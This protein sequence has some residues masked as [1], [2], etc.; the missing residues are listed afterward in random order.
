[1]MDDE[2]LKE[3]YEGLD[4]GAAYA[5]R[6][7]MHVPEGLLGRRVLDVNCR[8]GKGVYKLAAAVGPE[9]FVLGT[10]MRAEQAEEARAGVAQALGR[11]G[12]SVSN[13]A[14][15]QAFPEDMGAVAADGSFDVVYVN[16]SLNVAFDPV[17]VLAEAYRVLAFGGRLVVDTVCADGPRDAAVQAGARRLGNCVQAAPAADELL[18]QLSALGFADVCV[19]HGEPVDVTAGVQDGVIAPFVKTKEA[20]TF[21]EV[22][23]QAV[24]SQDT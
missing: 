8:G 4:D 1:M 11:S 17:S 9:G 2:A 22:L 13:M 15:E 21:F 3:W 20:T 5:R 10:C 23:I 14:F 19:I 6:C 7:R 16:S 24:K 12:L 18:A